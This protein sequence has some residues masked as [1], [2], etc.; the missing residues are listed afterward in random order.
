MF[1]IKVTYF[2]WN[3]LENLLKNIQPITRTGEKLF[4]DIHASA[5]SASAT[6]PIPPECVTYHFGRLEPWASRQRRDG[7]VHVTG[8]VLSGC[9]DKGFSGELSWLTRQ[10][11]MADLGQ[12]TRFRPPKPSPRK[13]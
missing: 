13:R 7:R 6:L 8:S 10:T 4:L 2:E 12:H 5:V 11:D 3:N 9:L 1:L